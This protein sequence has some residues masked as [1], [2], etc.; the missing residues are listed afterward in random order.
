MKETGKTTFERSIFG[1]RHQPRSTDTPGNTIEKFFHWYSIRRQQ[2]FASPCLVVSTTSN[3]SLQKIEAFSF[4]LTTII[5]T[6]LAV[7]SYE[8]TRELER[9]KHRLGRTNPLGTGQSLET[10]ASLIANR[11]HQQTPSGEGFSSSF[12]EKGKTD[13]KSTTEENRFLPPIQFTLDCN[14]PDDETDHVVT[15]NTMGWDNMPPRQHFYN[16]PD[17]VPGILR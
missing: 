7:D 10:F 6:K 1:V 15:T 3:N 13:T 5:R 12:L 9:K 14:I 17:S 8:K 16:M 2:C 4:V 11:K